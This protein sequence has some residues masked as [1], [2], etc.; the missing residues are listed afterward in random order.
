MCATSDM[1]SPAPWET[2]TA[3]IKSAFGSSCLIC[4]AVSRNF[5]PV[6]VCGKDLRVGETSFLHVCAG[7]FLWL[8]P[9]SLQLE[10]GEGKRA[11]ARWEWG[12]RP[13]QILPWKGSSLSRLPVCKGRRGAGRLER[14]R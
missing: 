8:S 7:T 5:G 4:T 10:E 14:N 3:A 2:A 6:F 9:V 11:E 13:L 1:M 12:Q